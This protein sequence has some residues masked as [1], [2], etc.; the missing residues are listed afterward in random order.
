MIGLH[1][2]SKWMPA[3]N[4]KSYLWSFGK[5]DVHE[6]FQ[7]QDIIFGVREGLVKL[8]IESL[9]FEGRIWQSSEVAVRRK[10]VR[11]KK[12]FCVVAKLGSQSCAL[13]CG[14]LCRKGSLGTVHMRAPEKM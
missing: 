3:D 12:M 7:Y 14:V 8:R 10:A 11:E 13:N 1:A 2:C 6:I 5:D 9:G 4:R